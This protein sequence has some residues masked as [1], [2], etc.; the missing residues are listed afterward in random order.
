MSR[1]GPSLTTTP[2]LV[3]AQHPPNRHLASVSTTSLPQH[4]QRRTNPMLGLRPSNQFPSPSAVN[5]FPIADERHGTARQFVPPS[6]TRE[7]PLADSISTRTIVEELPLAP[8][9]SPKIQASKP[10]AP[11]KPVSPPTSYANVRRFL[12]P[13][14]R[15]DSSK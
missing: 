5:V 15:M 3:Q 6:R 10:S 13:F 1:Q 9:K 12:S 14:L 11:P 7:F 8:V 2:S 4:P